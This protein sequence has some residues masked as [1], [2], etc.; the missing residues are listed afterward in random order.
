M[1]LTPDVTPYPSNA[2]NLLS[3]GSQKALRMIKPTKNPVG[4]K[5][6]KP[7][8]DFPL[9]P[10]ATGR[11]AKKIRGNFH[12]FGKW[13]NWQDALTLY[14]KQAAT[15]TRDV[16]LR[17]DPGGATIKDLL[18]QFLS[19]K[20]HLVDTG[21]IAQRTWDDYDTTCRKSWRSWAMSGWLPTCGPMIWGAPSPFCQ[22][23]GHGNDGQRY[24]L[25]AVLFKYAY[26]AG[27]DRAADPIRT[28]FKPP[29]RKSL[30]KARQEKGPRM[31]QADEIRAC[32]TRPGSI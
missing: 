1:A 5:P 15:F 26:D 29:S 30:R 16:S 20:K 27:L 25:D 6:A 7:Y 22:G 28:S 13:D 12:Y 21:E 2:D 14:Q 10:H 8:P 18:D 11:W 24:P 3:L 9:F 17:E 31:F 32:G 19:A 4:D 23:A